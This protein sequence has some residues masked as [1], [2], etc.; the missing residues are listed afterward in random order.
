[1]GV[2][3]VVLAPE[4]PLVASLTSPDKQG[5]VKEYQETVARKSDLERTSTGSDKGKTGVFLGTYATHPLS[6]K[7]V[8]IWIADYVLASYGTGAVMAVPGH[9]ERDFEFAVKFNLPIEQVIAPSHVKDTEN[10]P[11]TGEG[12]LFN[13]GDKLNGLK[14]SDAKDVIIKELS[15]KGFGEKKI[16]YKLRD[17]I[18]SRQRYWGEPIPI[19]FPVTILPNEQGLSNPIEGAPYEIHYDQPIAVEEKD[20]PLKLPPMTDFHPGDDPQG[21]LARAKEWR[22]FQKE[23]GKWYARET[24]TM[25]QV[26][27]QLLHSFHLLTLSFSLFFIT[28]VGG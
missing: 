3:Y 4:H 27:S 7:K 1:M 19:Y 5:A 8:P 9:D 22:F 11:F 21:C 23:D 2:T 24:N 26:S 17:W 13:S 12:Y 16:S 28:I 10:I 6:G 25:P 20:L 14:S 15:A 18:F